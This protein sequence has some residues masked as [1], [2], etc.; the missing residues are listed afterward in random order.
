MTTMSTIQALVFIAKAIIVTVQYL[1]GRIEAHKFHKSLD[2][3][4][5]S[6]E[7]ATTGPLP[8]RLEGGSEV[9]DQIN[10]NSK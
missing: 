3:M 6:I 4:K 9:E 10:E 8:G 2:E 1:T 5:A 7:K